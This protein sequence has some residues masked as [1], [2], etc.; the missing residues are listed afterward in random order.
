MKVIL[1][2][3]QLVRLIEKLRDLIQDKQINPKDFIKLNKNRNGIK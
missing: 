3:D 1:R 2:R